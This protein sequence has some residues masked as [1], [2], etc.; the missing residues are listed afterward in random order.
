[1]ANAGVALPWRVPGPRTAC[2][3]V[4]AASAVMPAVLLIGAP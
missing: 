3:V 1:M 4:W 2:T